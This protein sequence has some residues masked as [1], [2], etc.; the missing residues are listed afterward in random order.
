[1]VHRFVTVCIPIHEFEG[2]RL[3][4]THQAN[5]P[6]QGRGE[7]VHGFRGAVGEQLIAHMDDIAE[8]FWATDTG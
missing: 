7:E 2:Y 4:F 5:E 6:T 8:I 1:V 3:V